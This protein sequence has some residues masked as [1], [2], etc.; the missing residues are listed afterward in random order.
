MNIVAGGNEGNHN[1]DSVEIN[2]AGENRWTYGSPLPNKLT[3][4]RGVTLMSQFYITGDLH[5]YWLLCCNYLF[6]LT[7]WQGL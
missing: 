1:V 3:Q 6:C 2:V 4:L 7:R 5:C